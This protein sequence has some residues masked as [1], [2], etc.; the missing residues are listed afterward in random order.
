[1]SCLD[2]NTVIEFLDRVLPLAQRA[3]VEAHMDGCADCRELVALMGDMHPPASR[4][5]TVALTEASVHVSVDPLI[6]IGVKDADDSGYRA[7]AQIAA[8]Y[9]L[10]RCI[11]EGGMGSVWVARDSKLDRAVAIKVISASVAAKYILSRFEREAMAVARLRSPHIVQIHDYGIERGAP[12]MVME[13]LAGED[14]SVR[15]ANRGRLSVEAT[16][17]LVGQVAKALATAHHEGIVHRDLK[18]ANVFLH[19]DHDDE[20]VKVV[21]FGVAK[22]LRDLGSAGDTTAEGALLGTPRY[23]SP[24]QSH[25]A[26]AVDHRTDLWSLGVIAYRALTGILPFD[27]EGLG[28]VLH[29]IANQ[30]PRRVTKLVPDLPRE[31]DRFFERALAK[32]PQDR[33]ATALEMADELRRIADMPVSTREFTVVGQMDEVPPSRAVPTLPTV[34]GE[35]ET[36]GPAT[37]TAEH[38]TLGKFASRRLAPLLLAALALAAVVG[39]VVVRPWQGQSALS[40]APAASTARFDAREPERTSTMVSDVPDG[41]HAEA[42]S[43]SAVRSVPMSNAQPPRTGPSLVAS[44][45]PRAPAAVNSEKALF[46][47]RF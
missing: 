10:V 4:T 40:P 27:A 36:L 44:A 3:R 45:A 8:R 35:G 43:A 42:A 30:P 13:L 39:V 26:K 22:A 20:I 23:M 37:R 9:T 19:R 25:G 6:T 21:D 24:E 12:Y 18:P 34:P 11:G 41:A 17:V 33:F 5:P 47:G 15:L 38:S 28:D 7:G 14:L 16:A 1:V 46:K 32:E 2:E 29:K 31:V